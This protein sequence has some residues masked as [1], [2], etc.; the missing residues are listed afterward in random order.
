L[1]IQT[2]LVFAIKTKYILLELE[3]LLQFEFSFLPQGAH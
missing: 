1:Q 2:L 3:L